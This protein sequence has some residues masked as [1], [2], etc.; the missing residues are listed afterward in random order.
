MVFTKKVAD[1]YRDATRIWGKDAQRLMFIEEVGEAMTALSRYTRGRCC[2]E[3]VV[4]ELVDVSIMAEQ[5][6]LI[7][8]THDQYQ[9][10][11]NA[12]LGR[13]MKRLQA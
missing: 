7:Y 9:E 13:L 8:G 3:D 11:R 12:K 10:M 6:A 5:M 2:V 4:E 1:I